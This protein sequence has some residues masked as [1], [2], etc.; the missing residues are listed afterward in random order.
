M[1]NLLKIGSSGSLVTK[2]QQLLNSKGYICSIDGEYGPKTAVEVSLY[3]KAYNLR[4]DGTV[5]PQTWASMFT[6]PSKIDLWCHSAQTM[7]GYYA[8][9][10]N[11]Q[12]PQGTPA[13]ANNNPGNL[14][15]NNQ[16]NAVQN[17]KFAKFKT[18][19]DGY[20]ALKNLFTNACTGHSIRYKPTMTL[21][22]F[23]EVYAPSSDGNSP[24]AYAQHVATDLGVTVETIISTF[25]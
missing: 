16:T 10:E 2:V 7:E 14:V 13:W 18:Y 11:P 1:Q 8:P 22:Q 23:Y 4:A 21:L 25:L 17:G 15:W 12:Y 6:I 3:Q 9:G 5:G 20:N 24:M 19:T